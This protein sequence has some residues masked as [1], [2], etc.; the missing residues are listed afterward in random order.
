MELVSDPPVR[1][2][3][4]FD[5]AVIHAHGGRYP[6]LREA[7]ERGLRELADAEPELRD[8]LESLAAQGYAW[9]ELLDPAGGM[10]RLRDVYERPGAEQSTA[11]R[12]AMASAAVRAAFADHDADHVAGLARRTLGRREPTDHPLDAGIVPLAALALAFAGHLVEAERAATAA[13][14]RAERVGS[15]LDLGAACFVRSFAH[16]QTGRLADAIAD[17]E[18]AVEAGRHGWGATLPMAHAVLALALLGRGG[19][20]A[21]SIALELPGPGQRWLANV[22]YG[23][24]LVAHGEVTRAR[25]ESRRA[26]SQITQAG[27]LATMARVLNPV[28]CPWRPAAAE[29]LVDAGE[30]TRARGLIQEEEQLAARF[31]APRG[32][33][34]A[35]RARA[36]L[37]EPADAI[38]LLNDAAQMLSASGAA[39]E[40]AR[41]LIELGAAMRRTGERVAAREPLRDGT[42]LAHGCGGWPLVE[43]GMSELRRTGARPRR[44]ATR[45]L[46]ALTPAE[47]RVVGLAAA[48]HG[49]REIATRLYVTRRAVEMHLSNAYGKLGIASREELPGALG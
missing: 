1:A 8:E 48:G 16:L 26:L 39:L 31:G 30:L 42:E 36:S 18:R 14:E 46:D 17:G 25:G 6:Q 13:V 40:H 29:L 9:T 34:I 49:N 28:V 22:S 10:K 38:P 41:T 11:G 15:I 23:V 27:E 45:G 4:L 7:A 37:L 43:R 3:A 19:I 2:R 24:L 35:L 5:L 33:G 12:L 32:I 21:A 44:P 20:E 47:R